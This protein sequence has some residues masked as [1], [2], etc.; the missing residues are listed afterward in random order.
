MRLF[1]DLDLKFTTPFEVTTECD[2]SLYNRSNKIGLKPYE[3]LFETPLLNWHVF[4]SFFVDLNKKHRPDQSLEIFW[5]LGLDQY[6]GSK[7][8]NFQNLAPIQTGRSVE[9]SCQA[10]FL[11]VVVEGMFKIIGHVRF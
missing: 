11:E 5:K 2:K 6:S 3:F 1:D 8:E 9:S 7:I 4:Q 10:H